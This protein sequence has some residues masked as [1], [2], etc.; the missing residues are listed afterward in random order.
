[1]VFIAYSTILIISMLRGLSRIGFRVLS[2]GFRPIRFSSIFSDTL[3]Y[4]GWCGRVVAMK[5]KKK[6]KRISIHPPSWIGRKKIFFHRW[7][8]FKAFRSRSR[9]EGRGKKKRK[10]RE[11]LAGRW[12]RAKFGEKGFSKIGNAHVRWKSSRGAILNRES[13]TRIGWN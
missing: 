11:S 6:E 10:I 3:R 5:K 7:I 1:M 8:S 4:I 2:G 13:P 12:E 9:K